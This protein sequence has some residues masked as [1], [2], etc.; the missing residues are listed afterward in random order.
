MKK[1]V[2]LI[3]VLVLLLGCAVALADNIKLDSLTF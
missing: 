3:M 1:L 2:S